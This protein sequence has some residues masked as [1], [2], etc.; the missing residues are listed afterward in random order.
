MKHLILYS[1]L[2]IIMLASC[3]N[4]N[5]SKQFIENFNNDTD[6]EICL[7]IPEVGCGDCIAGG[8]YFLTQNKDK[9]NNS[10]RKNKVIF[11]A[12]TT[13]KML[14]R[15]LGNISLDSLYHEIDSDC[16]FL[17]PEPDGLYPVA[18][19]LKDGKIT[20]IDIQSPENEIFHK[21]KRH[22]NQQ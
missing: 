13:M 14:K 20:D 6:L 4:N 12:I 5:L 22:L 9:F 10:Q 17:L 8:V 19:Y 15:G 7:I 1:I 21:L 11:T 2:F 18:L 16:N 3:N